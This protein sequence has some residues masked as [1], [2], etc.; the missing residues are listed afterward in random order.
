MLGYKS[1]LIA[2]ESSQNI[3]ISK[4]IQTRFPIMDKKI[5]F[6]KKSYRKCIHYLQTNFCAT[7][8]N[9]AESDRL[10]PHFFQRLVWACQLKYDAATPGDVESFGFGV[11]GLATSVLAFPI[12]VA[13][14]GV[15]FTNLCRLKVFFTK[16]KPMFMTLLLDH[17]T[18]LR[19]STE[20]D[21]HL[22][23]VFLA[24]RSE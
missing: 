16:A 21:G 23:A 15:A 12:A 24:N 10:P 22:T 18:K 6:A 19:R 9:S 17:V 4:F 13:V 20:K 7:L 2:T 3:L 14:D 11:R 8:W 5:F 1:V